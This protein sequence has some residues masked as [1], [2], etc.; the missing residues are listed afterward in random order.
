[1]ICTM[2]IYIVYKLLY[3]KISLKELFYKACK[4][5]VSNIKV[6]FLCFL[7]FYFVLLLFILF[8]KNVYIYNIFHHFICNMDNLPK[9]KFIC[10][11]FSTV[12]V[13]QILY[14]LKC[15]SELPHGSN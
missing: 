3:E 2:Y 9:H 10:K 1:M 5:R 15:Y 4:N 14:L 11:V 8:V 12:S 7:V 6:I 13:N